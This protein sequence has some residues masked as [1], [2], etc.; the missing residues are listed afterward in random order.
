MTRM[1]VYFPNLIL[2]ILHTEMIVPGVKIC[3]QII[4]II[5]FE[6]DGYHD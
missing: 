3:T 2:T 6:K 5:H 4:F 1:A